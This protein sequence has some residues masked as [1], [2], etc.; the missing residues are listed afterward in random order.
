MKDDGDDDLDST[1][2]TIATMT[3]DKDSDVGENG[4]LTEHDGLFSPY[5]PTRNDSNL[6][7]LTGNLV[8]T[9]DSLNLRRDNV[10]VF[11]DLDGAPCDRSAE[12]L[13][14]TGQLPKKRNFVLARAN[15]TNL[16]KYKLILISIK[17]HTLNS[18]KVETV[19]EVTVTRELNLKS[20]SI[21]RTP[22][23]DGIPCSLV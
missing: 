7:L 4:D 6:G 22:Y 13:D 15:V 5:T 8:E 9:R 17:E 23:I 14:Q 2:D 3:E 21:A 12:L 20:V 18:T 1:F 11:I 16:R 10:V 19:T